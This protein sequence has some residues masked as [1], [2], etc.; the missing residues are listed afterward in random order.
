M[1]KVI[2]IALCLASSLFASCQKEAEN[3]EFKGTPV[4]IKAKIAETKATASMG[5]TGI[6]FAWEANESIYVISY[7]A[8]DNFLSNDVFTATN[9]AGADVVEFQGTITAESPEKIVCVY[10]NKTNP[11]FS[12]VSDH[13]IGLNSLSKFAN[14]DATAIQNAVVLVGEAEMTGGELSVTLS[15]INPSISLSIDVTSI[16]IPKLYRLTIEA[17]ICENKGFG[18]GTV[19]AAEVLKYGIYRGN[20]YEATRSYTVDSYIAQIDNKYIINVPIFFNGSYDGYNIKSGDTWEFT[21]SGRDA[22]N[23]D[24]KYKATKTF[25]KD[26]TFQAGVCYKISIDDSE[27]SEVTL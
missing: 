4:T 2:F 22:S 17:T 10:I 6:D 8:S 1:R 16:D 24:V 3:K 27:L 5:A 13:Y 18:S 20:S 11:S 7:G 25:N 15:H 14:G 26:F 12:I 23:N 21:I 9:E 19:S